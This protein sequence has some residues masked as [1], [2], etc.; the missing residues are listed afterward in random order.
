MIKAVIGVLAL[1][2]VGLVIL[3]LSEDEAPAKE[4]PKGFTASK[5]E[6]STLDQSE[7]NQKLFEYVMTGKEDEFILIRL[8]TFGANVNALDERGKTPIFYAVEM[9]NV[10]L[11]ETLRFKG[12]RTDIRDFSGNTVLDYV[13][14]TQEA[15]HDALRRPIKGNL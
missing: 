4:V 12:A 5:R 3:T 15:M 10:P 7:L 11:V 14:E 8:I 2:F 1:L 13:L 6:L 9:D